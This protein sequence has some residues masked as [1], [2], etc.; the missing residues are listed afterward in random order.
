[1]SCH[2]GIVL[3]CLLRS[4]M[5]CLCYGSYR[6]MCACMAHICMQRS[7]ELTSEEEFEKKR[8]LV[9]QV[10]T[11]QPTCVYVY[12]YICMC[13]CMCICIYICICICMYIC[14]YVCISM[15]ET[16]SHRGLLY[17]ATAMY[18][19]MYVCTY[20][21]C[22]Y[23]CLYVPIYI[24]ICLAIGVASHASARGVYHRG[25]GGRRRWWRR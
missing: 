2:C 12:I 8:K 5:K 25:G 16:Y 13:I 20:V 17:P 11:P 14:M 23:V 3:I 21:S 4:L 7:S 15:N 19:C 22:T 18:V 1:M 6:R 9:G 24:Y 10:N